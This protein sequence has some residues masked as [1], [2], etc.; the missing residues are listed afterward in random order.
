MPEI[1]GLIINVRVLAVF[2]Y[3]FTL[4]CIFYGGR[5]GQNANDQTLH[6][7]QECCTHAQKDANKNK[8]KKYKT[9]MP[10]KNRRH[11]TTA[12]EKHSKLENAANSQTLEIHE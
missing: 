6:I 11:K 10:H 4:K 3:I 8:N 2:V 7:V 12:K 5:Q 9:H 1:N